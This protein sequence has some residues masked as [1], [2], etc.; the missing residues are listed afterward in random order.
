MHRKRNGREPKN[1]WTAVHYGLQTVERKL[2]GHL[3]DFMSERGYNVDILSKQYDGL[4]LWRDYKTGAF[5]LNLLR[6]A[7]IHLA[8]QDLG[9]GLKVPMKLKEKSVKCPYGDIINP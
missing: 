8:S 4:Y 9:G 3:R 7:E 2:L 6:T 5:P 1:L